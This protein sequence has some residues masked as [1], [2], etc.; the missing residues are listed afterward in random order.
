MV[1]LELFGLFLLW[2]GTRRSLRDMQ[3]VH[4]IGWCVTFL[5]F[6]TPLLAISIR[7]PHILLLAAGLP[8]DLH[9]LTHIGT[10]LLD[11]I[12]SVGVRSNGDPLFWVGHAPLL[13][14]AELVLGALGCYFYLVQQRTVRAMFLTGSVVISL[15]LISF[16]GPV[17]FATL[18]PL[19]YLFIAHGL[20]NLMAQWFTVFPRNPIARGSGIAVICL[21]LFFSVLYQTRVYFVAWPHTTA[22]RQA[23]DLPQP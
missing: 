5:A 1:W 16:G 14:A 4:P 15:V 11:A 6:L 13:N 20:S 8:Q 12:M 19:L 2:P 22:T 9:N 3:P 10:N 21:M 23:F 17:G 7:S 18:V